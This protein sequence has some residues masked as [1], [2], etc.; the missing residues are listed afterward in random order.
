MW[1]AV[2]AAD[3]LGT[4]VSPRSSGDRAVASEAMRAGSNLAGGTNVTDL[5][6]GRLNL[7]TP[8]VIT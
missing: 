5:T 2:R 6:H 1:M 7:S 8:R 4:S 3:N